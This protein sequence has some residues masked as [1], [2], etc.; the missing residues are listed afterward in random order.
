MNDEQ[1]VKVLYAGLLGRDADPIGLQHHLATLE[2]KPADPQRYRRLL[3]AFAASNEFGITADRR[4]APASANTLLPDMTAVAFGHVVSLGS[5]CHAA[6]ALKRAG[7]RPWSG[8]FDWTFSSL[9]MVAHAIQDN[10]KEFLD[11][12]HYRSVAL[13]ERVTPE[14]NLCEH[15]FYRHRDGIRFVFNHRDPASVPADAAHYGRATA[16][17]Q[18]V[19][20]STSWKLF[21]VV[22]P[23]QLKMPAIQPLL[24]A[25]EGA[26][27]N[28]MV[29]ALQFNT[30][31]SRSESGRLADAIR[32]ERMRH[33]LLKIELNVGTPSNGVEFPDAQDNRLLERLLKSF[34]IKPEPLAP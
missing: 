24:T 33:N 17:L 4:K 18:K 10:F 32:T 8:P 30:V 25:L 2:S 6:M 12:R 29:L 1:F 27:T 16:R 14:A 31:Q 3:E 7:L 28:F 13:Q 21:V 23:G 11:P 19:F 20:A 22:S 15:D 9:P 34:H 26:T 5:F